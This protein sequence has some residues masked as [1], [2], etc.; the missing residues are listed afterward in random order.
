MGYTGH[1][2][3]DV[4]PRLIFDLFMAWLYISVGS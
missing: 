1:V 3:S 4:D 2:C